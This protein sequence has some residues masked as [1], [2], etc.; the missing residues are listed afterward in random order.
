MDERTNVES[1][2]TEGIEEAPTSS[3]SNGGGDKQTSQLDAEQLWKAVEPFIEKKL[4]S[5]KDRRIA[6]LERTVNEFQPILERFKGIVPDAKLAEIQR[7]LEFEDI[8]RRVYGEEQSSGSAAG[9]QQ[10]NAAVDLAAVVDEVLG[11]PANDSRVTDLKLKYANNPKEYLSQSLQLLAK[12]GDQRESTPAE[13]P[14]V[15]GGVHRQTTNPIENIDDP[16]TLYR[17]AAQQIAKQ[18][19]GRKRGVAS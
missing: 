12:L 5:T 1:G 11:L 13:Q 10:N 9:N 15:S 6:Q 4:Q 14:I 2:Q 7:D 16:K 8:K 19:T 3:N 17:M 18:A